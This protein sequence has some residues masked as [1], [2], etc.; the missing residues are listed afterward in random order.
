MIAAQLIADGSID[1][2]H[3]RHC[4]L[5]SAVPLCAVEFPDGPEIDEVHEILAL[6]LEAGLQVSAGIIKG[7]VCL[8]ELHF[9]LCKG[10]VRKVNAKNLDQ[11]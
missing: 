11:A 6:I 5:T 2:Q 1:L 8:E 3:R 10:H 4:P 9:P 7:T